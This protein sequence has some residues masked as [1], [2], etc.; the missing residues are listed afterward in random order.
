MVSS[1]AI[2]FHCNAFSPD[3]Y[4]FFFL[5]LFKF[6][7]FTVSQKVFLTSL[8]WS[9][10]S[11]QCSFVSWHTSHYYSRESLTLDFKDSKARHV[12]QLSWDPHGMFHN[13][14]MNW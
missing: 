7:V 13:G 14:L 9:L 6:M 12:L 4:F 1:N 11:I 10:D 3:F 5:F 2:S 8:F